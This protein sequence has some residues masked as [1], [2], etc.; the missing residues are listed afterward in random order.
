MGYDLTEQR[1]TIHD[2]ILKT[3]SIFMVKKKKERTPHKIFACKR[4]LSKFH[5]HPTHH[6]LCLCCL[7]NLFWIISEKW[8]A[9]VSLSQ[10]F[11][12]ALAVLLD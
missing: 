6:P 4:V 5:L 2:L 3:V 7:S 11:L 12:A 9:E 8:K 10:L 1:P